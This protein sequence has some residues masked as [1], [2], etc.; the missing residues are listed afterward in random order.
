[1][2]FR[3]IDI[4]GQTYTEHRFS[5]DQISTDLPNDVFDRAF[6]S[7]YFLVIDIV[8]STLFMVELP[9]VAV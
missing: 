6:L 4:H 7:S 5:I 3:Q 8:E 2:A 1:V 9:I